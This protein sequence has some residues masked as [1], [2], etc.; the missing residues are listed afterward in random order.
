MWV[1]F[2]TESRSFN[3]EASL[4]ERPLASDTFTV[5][6]Q[7]KLVSNVY[8]INFIVHEKT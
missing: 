1:R 8:F 7:I 3:T 4:L 2:F 6:L 5:L